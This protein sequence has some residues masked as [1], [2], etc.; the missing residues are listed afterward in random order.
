MGEPM[1]QERLEKYIGLETEIACLEEVAQ[2]SAE[3]KEL[4]AERATILAAI[5]ALPDPW[6][7]VVLR[8]RYLETDSDTGQIQ[9]WTVVALKLYGNDEERH[10]KAAKRLHKSALRHLAEKEKS[11]P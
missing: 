1:T 3:L 11:H 9:M 8:R 4:K 7:R 5:A 6:E 2:D 10:V